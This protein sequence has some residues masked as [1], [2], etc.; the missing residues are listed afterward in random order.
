VTF[1]DNG[2]NFQGTARFRG[3]GPVG[4]RGKYAG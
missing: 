4:Y 3:E 1:F 2:T